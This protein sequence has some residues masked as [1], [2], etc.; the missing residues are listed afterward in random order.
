[1]QGVGR[2]TVAND[3][4]H[5]AHGGAHAT[6]NSHLCGPEGTSASGGY[7][8]RAQS[9]AVNLERSHSIDERTRS[10]TPTICSNAEKHHQNEAMPTIR[11]AIFSDDCAIPRVKMCT[12]IGRGGVPPPPF[13]LYWAFDCNATSE[14]TFPRAAAEAQIE[15]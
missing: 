5:G 4:P 1:M 2:D 7:N 6:T 11:T 8:S 12:P 3:V 15:V 9:G 14:V 13:H 10:N